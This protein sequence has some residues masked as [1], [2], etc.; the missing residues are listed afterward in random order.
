MESIVDMANPDLGEEEM[1]NSL[2]YKCDI[3][4]EG[5]VFVSAIIQYLKRCLTNENN[6]SNLIELEEILD[7]DSIDGKVTLAGYRSSVKKWISDIRNRSESPTLLEPVETIHQLQE[8]NVSNNATDFSST[9]ETSVDGSL[10]RIDNDIGELMNQIEDLKYLNHKLSEDNLQL[11]CQ[12]DTQDEQ[13]SQL[14]TELQNKNKEEEQLKKKLKSLQDLANLTQSVM[15]ENEELKKKLLT[16]EKLNKDLDGRIINLERERI[17]T[18]KQLRDIENKWLRSCNDLELGLVETQT[19]KTLCNEQKKTEEIKSLNEKLNTLMSQNEKLQEEKED[20]HVQLAQMNGKLLSY[21]SK[22]ENIGINDCSFEGVKTPSTKKSPKLW[23]STPLERH[24]ICMELK[25]RLNEDKS[26]PSPFCE[27]FELS[28]DVTDYKQSVL[29]PPY[30]SAWDLEFTDNSQLDVSME[31]LSKNTELSPMMTNWLD[32]L[33]EVS[34]SEKKAV[35]PAYMSNWDMSSYCGADQSNNMVKS[36][37]SL[38]PNYVHSEASRKLQQFVDLG[39][40]ALQ[41]EYH[42]LY[43][44]NLELAEKCHKSELK[45]A[46]LQEALYEANQ[47][48]DIDKQKVIDL[49]ESFESS[50]V[51]R[52]LDLKDLWRLMHNPDEEDSS[53][54][55]ESISGSTELLK[56]QIQ[57]E[58]KVLRNKLKISKLE[59]SR[60]QQYSNKKRQ[61][62]SPLVEALDIGVDNN[63]RNLKCFTSLDDVDFHSKN[64]L[65]YTHSVSCK[66]ILK[67]CNRSVPILHELDRD[68][69]HS[70]VTEDDNDIEPI[71]EQSDN[72]S[73]HSDSVFNTSSE[74]KKMHGRRDIP[75]RFQSES[76]MDSSL[77]T[78]GRLKSGDLNSVGDTIIIAENSYKSGTNNKRVRTDGSESSDSMVKVGNNSKVLE[79]SFEKIDRVD[80]SLD[81]RDMIDVSKNDSDKAG[82]RR[83]SYKK[84]I[85][86]PSSSTTNN[87][88]L[89]RSRSDSFQKAIEQGQVSLNRPCDSITCNSSVV[90]DTTPEYDLV[91]SISLNSA[92]RYSSTPFISSSAKSVQFDFDS[93]PIDISKELAD[94]GHISFNTGTENIVKKEISDVNEHD[95]VL[96]S[97]S[98]HTEFNSNGSQQLLRS[99]KCNEVSTDNEL[100]SDDNVEKVDITS[101]TTA[102]KTSL[103]TSVSNITN[104]TSSSNPGTDQSSSYSCSAEFWSLSPSSDSL[105]DEEVSRDSGHSSSIASLEKTGC[106]VNSDTDQSI[107]PDFCDDFKLSSLLLTRSSDLSLV[108]SSTS[109]SCVL[110]SSLP[111]Y[112]YC[113]PAS[114]TSLCNTSSILSHSTLIPHAS[115]CRTSSLLND[116]VANGEYGLKKSRKSRC[117]LRNG[118]I[119]KPK[120]PGFSKS[121]QEERS[122]SPSERILQRSAKRLTEKGEKPM[123]ELSKTIDTKVDLT[124]GKSG[125]SIASDNIDVIN[126]DIKV[127]DINVDNIVH[128]H[129]RKTE[130]DC[131]DRKIEADTSGNSVE[132]T[133]TNDTIS[134]RRKKLTLVM[135]DTIKDNDGTKSD[136]VDPLSPAISFHQGK[137]SLSLFVLLCLLD[138]DQLPILDKSSES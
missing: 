16:S 30:M 41:K 106:N 82:F 6:E 121:Y 99:S 103:K 27:K 110:S 128:L 87:V 72:I 94:D 104:V 26:L 20:V 138:A 70:V 36:R 10:S 42:R 54:T 97:D 93:Q 5:Q 19:L 62:L 12:L 29:L 68:G 88:H 45:E 126:N 8:N 21:Q 95:D 71:E 60:L 76:S 78:I 61:P 69:A 79:T 84:A 122:L 119:Q 92:P 85:N 108:I 100:V 107:S 75:I 109:T 23:F 49:E 59:H 98:S 3:Y 112:S 118:L 1:I 46:E 116:S 66:Q 91:S 134:S 114:S 33:K 44:S 90:T 101:S 25:D 111:A 130:A 127:S 96:V 50:V 74:M 67:K 28:H 133:N 55:E 38:S 7:T 9:V 136:I 11:T 89:V 17:D 102:L 24:S 64:D 124:V 120:C 81:D 35:L 86:N 117:P 115:K 34:C 48:S 56:R 137:A 37:R 132:C 83:R 51:A 43:R 105:G 32:S 73:E 129:D 4:D 123:N 65:Q 131:V 80:D 14:T 39:E 15:E 47:R 2:F 57:A 113:P 18:E 77:V 53:D 63:S 22:V 135:P 58:I 40:T 52:K 13:I 31:M 125:K